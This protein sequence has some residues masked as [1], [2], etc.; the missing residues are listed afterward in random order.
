MS[1]TKT[2]TIWC[3]EENC[4]DWEHGEDTVNSSRKYLHKFGW[5]YVDGKDYCPYHAHKKGLLEYPTGEHS[6]DYNI[7]KKILQEKEG[8]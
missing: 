1:W 2:V 6:I 7:E 4:N 3:D 5:R 8:Y